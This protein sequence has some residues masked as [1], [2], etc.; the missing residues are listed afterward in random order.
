MLL[1][2]SA[3]LVG[4]VLGLRYNVFV[5]IPTSL[6]SAGAVFGASFADS[7][8]VWAILLI[9]TF[10]VVALQLGYLAGNFASRPDYSMMRPTPGLHMCTTM[11]LF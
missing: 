2:A 4:A 5:L 11:L 10:S 1:L 6:M 9:T 7:H 8:Y 3:L